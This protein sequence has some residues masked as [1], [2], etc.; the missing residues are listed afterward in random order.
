ML[1]AFTYR[2]NSQ[3]FG[4]YLEQV[5]ADFFAHRDVLEHIA[6]LDRVL[7]RQRFLLLNLLRHTGHFLRRAGS[8]EKFLKELLELGVDQF[9]DALTGLRVLLDHLH[10]AFDFFL[11]R[12]TLNAAGIEAHHTRT[13]TV[14]KLPGRVTRG[15]KKI[16]FRQ[17][18]AQHRHLKPGEPHPYTRGNT[19]FLQ[20]GLEHQGH[21][22]D[23]GLLA[24]GLGLFLEIRGLLTQAPRNPRHPGRAVVVDHGAGA[25]VRGR[26]VYTHR[27]GSG[28]GR[29]SLLVRSGVKLGADPPYQQPLELA[30]HTLRPAARP[31]QR[32]CGGHHAGFI[33]HQ[34][35]PRIR[36]RGKRPRRQIARH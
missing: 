8:G 21:D 12:A 35:M 18:H 2:R 3:D 33:L 22:F 29:G 28:Q 1:R 23:R 10:H 19:I 6:H 17:G 5:G 9:V 11:K 31:A 24:F 30:Q 36:A 14:D 25:A 13:H 16:R 32:R 4:P 27:D 34:Y 20:N 7:D 15:T 26:A